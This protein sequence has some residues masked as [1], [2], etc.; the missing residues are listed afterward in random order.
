MTQGSQNRGCLGFLFPSP[1]TPDTETPTTK[2]DN[3]L[4]LTGAWP[5]VK[6]DLLSPAEA[7]FYRVLLQAAGDTFVVSPKVKLGDLINVAQGTP[8]WKGWRSKIDRK[9]ADYVLVQR[10]TLTARA[11]IELDDASHNTAKAKE[12]DAVKNQ[13]LA[14]AGLPLVRIKARKGYAVDEVRAALKAG[15]RGSE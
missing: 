2:P 1:A 7:S 11:V 3:S 6:R 5:Y 9:H 14:A 12:R 4:D 15:L 10:D 13:A 8:K